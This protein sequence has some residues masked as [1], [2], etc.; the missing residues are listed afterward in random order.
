MYKYFSLF[1]G[2]FLYTYVDKITHVVVLSTNIGPVSIFVQFEGVNASN[3]L[4]LQSLSKV[5][6]TN[7]FSW[8]NIAVGTMCQSEGCQPDRVP[9]GT[10]FASRASVLPSHLKLATSNLLH[11]HDIRK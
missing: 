2:P 9:G 7:G 10:K 6:M 4:V 8:D 5:N 3:L 11:I 1:F